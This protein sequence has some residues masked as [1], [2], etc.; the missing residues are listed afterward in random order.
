MVIDPH[1]HIFHRAVAGGARAARARAAQRSTRPGWHAAPLPACART[2]AAAQALEGGL[3]LVPYPKPY[4]TSMQ[5][6]LGGAWVLYL[7]E[8]AEGVPVAV[9]L[10]AGAG[11]EGSRP[12]PKLQEVRAPG[13]APALPPAAAQQIRLRCGARRAPA[14]EA[15]AGASTGREH[16]LTPF[17]PCRQALTQRRPGNASRSPPALAGA[18]R[19]RG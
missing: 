1:R 19:L 12:L 17:L 6:E 5:A 14:P 3:V 10:P 18:R 2:R 16:P 9:V 11:V 15:A 13:Q 8:D 4:S 7:L